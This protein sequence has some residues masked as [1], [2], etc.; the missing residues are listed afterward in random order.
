MSQIITKPRY[1]TFNND[2]IE[3]NKL[4]PI[5][6]FIDELFIIGQSDSAINIGK[7]T[8]VFES[9]II[10]ITSNIN[11]LLK[12]KYLSEFNFIYH[13]TAKNESQEFKD[14]DKAK[15][16]I[17]QKFENI[18][19]ELLIEISKITQYLNSFEKLKE[20]ENEIIE[21]FTSL[22]EEHVIKDLEKGNF[23][24]FESTVRNINKTSQ[25]IIYSHNSNQKLLK[26]NSNNND[27]DDANCNNFMVT[28]VV[29]IFTLGGF[30]F[31][32]RYY[33]QD[34]LIRL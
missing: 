23:S 21:M 10:N 11:R 27:V 30:Y 29:I 7:K 34:V 22:K 33:N 12:Q 5:S 14:Y 28:G 16:F 26:N 19:E 31:Y 1:N 25:S 9:S 17:I 13:N 24:M 20:I 6:K 32:R 8:K 2:D 4:N 18:I 3:N 15:T